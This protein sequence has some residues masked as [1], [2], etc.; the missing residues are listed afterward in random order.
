VYSVLTCDSSRN[1]AETNTRVLRV[2]PETQAYS[3]VYYS[4]CSGNVTTRSPVCAQR[5][6]KTHLDVL[7]STTVFTLGRQFGNGLAAAIHS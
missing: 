4:H 5:P 6:A 2:L 3:G 7:Q 1:S